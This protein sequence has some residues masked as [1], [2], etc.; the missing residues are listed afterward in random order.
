[1]LLTALVVWPLGYLH[2]LTR[3]IAQHRFHVSDNV[4]FGRPVAPEDELS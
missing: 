1:M 2:P 3:S 4:R